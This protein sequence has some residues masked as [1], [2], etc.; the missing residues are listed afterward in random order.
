MKQH[1]T[2]FDMEAASA[3]TVAHHCDMRISR[4]LL[5]VK[6]EKRAMGKRKGPFTFLE[7]QRS[8]ERLEDEVRIW[9]KDPFESPE[10]VP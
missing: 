4:I 5:A 1:I 9:A 10:D 7:M 2:S 8:F 6:R 3:R